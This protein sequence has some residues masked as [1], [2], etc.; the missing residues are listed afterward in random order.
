MRPKKL[1][2]PAISLSV[3]ALLIA[4]MLADPSAPATPQIVEV[5]L[6]THAP[7]TP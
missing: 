6:E 7:N 5:P 4:A 1:L 2:F 3:L